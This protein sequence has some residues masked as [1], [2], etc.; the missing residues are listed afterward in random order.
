MVVINLIKIDAISDLFFDISVFIFGKNKTPEQSMRCAVT[1]SVG[2]IRE[3]KFGL[4]DLLKDELEINNSGRFNMI[5]KK[6][7]L[8]CLLIHGLTKVISDS[9]LGH[10]AGWQVI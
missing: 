1:E 2:T 7:V 6:N 4:I 9:G 10:F 8:I 5:C 3:S